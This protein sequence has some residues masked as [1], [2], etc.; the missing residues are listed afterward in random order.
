MAAGRPKRV[1]R[2]RL[3]TSAETLY[4]EFRTFIDGNVRWESDP[5]QYE[6]LIRQVGR[7]P[8][9][10]DDNNRRSFR[11]T[12]EDEIRSGRLAEQL[13]QQRLRELELDYRVRTRAWMKENLRGLADKDINIPGQP[14][15][16][17]ALFHAGT[18]AEVRKICAD[19]YI[20]RRIEVQPGVFGSVRTPKW[21]I[22]EMSP[23]PSHLERYAEQFIEAKRGPRYPR[24]RR[25]STLLKQLW[26]LSRTLAGAAYGE[27]PR[28]SIN[29]VGSKRPEQIF[30]E[31]S[32]ATPKRKKRR[33]AR[34]HVH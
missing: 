23:L 1:D 26:F 21:P 5:E 24:S 14:E 3:Y 15:V 6:Q 8:I 27:S 28:T 4:W 17:K 19:A 34:A 29:L 25:P 13:R 11:L 20:Q 32:A 2:R 10:V 31:S 18:A 7:G 9:P 16:L 30:E 22:N 33:M 12:V